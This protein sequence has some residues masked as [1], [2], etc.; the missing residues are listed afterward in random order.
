MKKRECLKVI[1]K[2]G[3]DVFATV[4][5]EPNVLASGCQDGEIR[6]FDV[7][8]GNLVDTLEGHSE[9]VFS[10]MMIN[11]DRLVSGSFDN[12]IK[13]WDIKS[14]KCIQT[15]TGHDH[16]TTYFALVNI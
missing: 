12:S 14:R 1:D 13:I 3:C 2:T 8:S 16:L 10:L 7:N 11:Q 4:L 6:L 9:Y 15:L 5:V